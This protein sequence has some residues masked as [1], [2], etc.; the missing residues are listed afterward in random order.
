MLFIF[1]VG[2]P[3]PSKM[4]MPP[5]IFFH[6][7]FGKYCFFLKKLTNEKY[8]E[9]HFLQK[10]LYRFCHQRLPSSQTGHVLLQMI[11]AVF[12]EKYCFFQKTCLIIKYLIPKLW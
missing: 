10:K 8:S 7:Y 3:F 11:F 9:P 4:I 1:V 12:S 6:G 5:K 2:R